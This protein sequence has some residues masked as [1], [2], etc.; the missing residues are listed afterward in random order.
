MK[1]VGA[2]GN[3]SLRTARR[4]RFCLARCSSFCVRQIGQSTR[5][6]FWFLSFRSPVLRLP[7]YEQ[8]QTA[9]PI[10][11]TPGAAA[12]WTCHFRG[13][14]CA[15]DR[16]RTPDSAVRDEAACVALCQITLGNGN[17]ALLLVVK[18]VN[19]R[20]GSVFYFVWA[21]CNQKYLTALAGVVCYRGW[22]RPKS[23]SGDCKGSRI[24]WLLG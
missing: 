3:G 14:E 2:S 6:F 20:Y 5:A 19:L 18:R 21:K 22:S 1:V 9:L 23:V 13:P 11:R 17:S 16:R 10:G 7:K 24:S 12:L 15:V 4:A 8:R